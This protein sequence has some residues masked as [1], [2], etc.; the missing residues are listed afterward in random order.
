MHNTSSPKK[1]FFS[2]LFLITSLSLSAR[3]DIDFP[4]FSSG[5]NITET[6][7]VENNGTV[8]NLFDEMSFRGELAINQ[9][10]HFYA[11]ID[12][13][14]IMYKAGLTDVYSGFDRTEVYLDSDVLPQAGLNLH[15]GYGSH[16]ELLVMDFTQYRFERSSTS[17]IDGFD[18]STTL[19]WND[20]FYVTTAFNPVSFENINA[21]GYPDVFAAFFMDNDHRGS[22]WGPLI[23]FTSSSMQLFYDSSSNL[24]DLYPGEAMTLGIGGT[25]VMD[26]A[27]ID[28]LGFGMTEYF[29]MYNRNDS[30][31]LQAE[32]G[33]GFTIPALSGIEANLSGSNAMI[34][35]DSGDGS[36]M[37]FGLDVKAMVTDIF[38]V[39][40]AVAGIGILDKPGASAEGGV[41]LDFKYFQ[42]YTGYSD[43][44]IG[45]DAKYAKGAFDK[46]EIMDDGSTPGGGFFLTLKASF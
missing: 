2:T 27:G 7:K 21:G 46:I 33:A 9:F 20:R 28:I 15:M 38:G 10:T 16:Q 18:F 8:S 3:E 30:D 14:E 42:M 12:F 40:G 32:W 43:H 37:N 19:G 6:M 11:L 24:D 22:S 39:F 41:C 35:S 44:A 4:S 26:F 5:M 13:S 36:Y 34:L 25:L 29:L 17:G 1:L 23:N 31:I 45:T